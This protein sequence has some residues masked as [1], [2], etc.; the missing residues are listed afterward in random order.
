M[1]LF[2][3]TSRSAAS[4]ALSTHDDFL[5]LLDE[6]ATAACIMTFQFVQ[7]FLNFAEEFSS[8]SAVGVSFNSAKVLT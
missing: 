5:R 2:C 1:V 8:N 6:E 4:L 7:R 3:L